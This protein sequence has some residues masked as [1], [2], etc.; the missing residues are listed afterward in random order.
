MLQSVPRK[1]LLKLQKIGYESYSFKCK[2][3]SMVTVDSFAWLFRLAVNT[4][5]RIHYLE[6]DWSCKHLMI[7]AFVFSIV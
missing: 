5:Q 1:I 6:I 7:T 2:N 4:I 3:G